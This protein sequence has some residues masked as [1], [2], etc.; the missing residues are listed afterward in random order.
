MFG[1]SKYRLFLIVIFLGAW[2]VAAIRPVFPEGWLLENFLVFLIPVLLIL[3]GKKLRWSETSY[4][5]LLILSVLH[6]IGAHYTYEY[7]PFGDTLGEWFGTTRN[8][9]DRLVH[10]AFGLLMAYPA[11][12]ILVRLAGVRNGWSYYLPVDI[13]ISLSALYEIIE[14]YSAL[15]VSPEV[16][17]AFLGAQGDIWDAQA[18]MFMAGCGAIIAMMIVWVLKKKFSKIV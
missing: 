14:W 17:L 12:E 11:R 3:F 5:L 15:R 13:I 7:V 8:M 10:F 9:Y 2:I 18:D 6:L 4:T 1:L 16:G